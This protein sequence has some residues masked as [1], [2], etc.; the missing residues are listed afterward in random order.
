MMPIGITA[1]GHATQRLWPLCAQQ[2]AAE[3]ERGQHTD[4]EPAGHQVR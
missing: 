1:R 2:Q 4:G 3:G